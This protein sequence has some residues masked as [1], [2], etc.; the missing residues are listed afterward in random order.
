[1][2]GRCVL[3]SLRPTV[4]GRIVRTWCFVARVLWS[5]AVLQCLR[6]GDVTE[7]Q[8]IC[9]AA[10]QHWR[11]ASLCGGT[12]WTESDD[13]GRV[14]NPFRLLWKWSHWCNSEMMDESDRNTVATVNVYERAI[15]ACC[16]GNPYALLK[17]P[18]IATWADA[19]WG[20]LT[21][22]HEARVA[23][24]LVKHREAQWSRTQ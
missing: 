24:L 23:D 17:S 8:R 18:C 9:V 4:G 14:G 19:L 13:G 12:Y 11:S 16:A 6:C 10:N 5:L 7:A 22:V 15:S 21:S 3:F 1:M 2:F 20:L